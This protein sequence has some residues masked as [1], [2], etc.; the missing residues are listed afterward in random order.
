MEN[1]EIWYMAN[2]CIIFNNHRLVT[3]SKAWKKA[4][5]FESGK[6][7]CIFKGASSKCLPLVR[8]NILFVSSFI[9][10]YNLFSMWVLILRKV[11]GLFYLLGGRS[12]GDSFDLARCQQRFSSMGSGFRWLRHFYCHF[13]WV[14]VF[15]SGWELAWVVL[16]SSRLNARHVSEFTVHVAYL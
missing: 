1:T 7:Y 3:L 15:A 5:N 12:S 9:A 2:R 11:S 6:F 10:D 4:T 16:F 13:A 14:S 8:P